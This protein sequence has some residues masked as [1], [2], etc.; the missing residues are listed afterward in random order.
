MVKKRGMTRAL[1][2]LTLLLTLLTPALARAGEM[3]VDE[4]GLFSVTE[5]AQIEE[6]I[7]DIRDT[8]QMDAVVMTS[9]KVPDNKSSTTEEQ[10]QDFADEYFDQNGYGLG[11]DRAGVLY[12]ID[13]NNR[14]LYLGTSGVM[15]DCINDSRLEKLLDT[16]YQWAASGNYGQ[17]AIQILKQLKGYLNE[18][19]EEGSFR[20][21]A[22]TGQRLTGLYNKLTRGETIFAG[23]VGIAACVI[24]YLSVAAKYGLKRRT[25]KFNKD[26]QSLAS[27][28]K[29]EKT[30][31]RQTVTRTRVPR[32]GSG[33]GGGGG[34]GRGS[35]VH[36]SSGGGMHG[37]GGRH[38]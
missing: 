3:V 8:Y 38:F 27:Y 24:M 31:L 16:A 32:G 17:S 2:I 6:L 21:D 10:T 26:T 1:L 14:V 5:I 34:G 29:D 12:L 20:Y 15:I 30:F 37:G 4:C 35:G 19:I 9:R 25:Y 33:G 22:V 23:A 7:Q 28:R 18:G 36:F 13:V 11:E